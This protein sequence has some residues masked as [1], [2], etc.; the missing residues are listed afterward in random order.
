MR[1]PLLLGLSARNGE[2]TVSSSA[3][4]YLETA[5][6]AAVFGMG[7]LANKLLGLIL[8][9]LYTSYLS[10]SDYGILSLLAVTGSLVSILWTSGLR[11]AMFKHYFVSDELAKRAEVISSAL[12]W[13]AGT[14]VG[15]ILLFWLPAAQWAT[16]LLDGPQGAIYFRIMGWVIFFNGIETIPLVVLRSEKKSLQ[17]ALFSLASF[18]LGAGLSIYLVAFQGMGVL[19]TRVANLI[20]SALFAGIGLWICR[21]YLRATFSRQIVVSLLRYGLPL[22]PAGLA[23]YVLVQADRYFLKV[24]ADLAQTGIYSI[25]YQCGMII[26]LIIVQPLQLIWLPTAFEMQGKKDA[27]SFFGRVLT[28]Y[29]VLSGWLALGLSLL[30]KEVILL[31]TTARFH[32]AYGVV[33]WVSY[34]YVAYGAYMVVNI[35]T[36]LTNRTA[37]AW[38]IVAVAAGANLALNVLLIPR[39]GMYGAAVATLVSYVF[40]AWVAWFVNQRLYPIR[41][42]WGR[43]LKVGAIN[44]LLL[45]VGWWLLPDSLLAAVA[46]KLLLLVA[47]WGLLL[48]V[49][50]FHPAE[51]AFARSLYTKFRGL[52]S[53]RR[54]A[55]RKG[56][57][58]A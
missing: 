38:K 4:K 35:G 51:L 18:V 31:M 5:K 48:A 11:T 10:P 58:L 24:F 26:N 9:P 20:T 52:W 33:P 27:K 34:A 55:A 42:E 44:G 57:P 40:L 8:L 23:S 36:Y 50:F 29:T 54:T 30:G 47:Y 7:S 19:G 32:A 6:H 37:D 39:L 25:G 43:L 53:V 14:G 41:Y 49:R 12:F 46:G 15:A 3:R 22:V 13:I 2:K 16:L 1:S 28:Y 17:Y 56:E 45:A 21:R